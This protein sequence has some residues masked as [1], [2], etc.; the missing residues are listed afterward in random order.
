MKELVKAH[1]LSIL[2]AIALVAMFLPFAS[3][4]FSMEIAGTSAGDSQTMSGFA[5]MQEQVTGFALV[6]GPVLLV[7]MNYVKQLE[8]YKGLLAIVIPVVCIAVCI[9]MLMQVKEI[10]VNTMGGGA[11][12]FG[13]ELKTNIGIGSIIAL[14]SY[15]GMIVYGGVTYHNLTLD[16]AGLEKLKQDSTQFLQTAQQKLSETTQNVSD[17]VQSAANNAD[18]AK[19]HTETPSSK[20]AARKLNMNRTEEVLEMIEKLSKMKD[21]GILSEEEFTEKKKQ[22]LSEI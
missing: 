1:S 11:G 17:A 3:V 4:S 15:V 7:A 2:C 8:K 6:I 20:P 10:A 18:A 5:A 9:G 13:M 12:G 21:A 19:V 14:L 22:L 16:R